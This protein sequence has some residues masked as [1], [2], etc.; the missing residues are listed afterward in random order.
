MSEN[1]MDEKSMIQSKTNIKE[2]TG[3][4][5]GIERRRQVSLERGGDRSQ[6][7]AAE[8]LRAASVLSPK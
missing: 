6:A 5:G 7:E 1:K 2:K 8:M 3:E 4:E